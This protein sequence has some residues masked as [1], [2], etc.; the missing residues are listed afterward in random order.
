MVSNN[1]V[2]YPATSYLIDRLAGVSREVHSFDALQAADTLFGS[3]AP[4]NF[5]LVGAA[6]QSGALMIPAQCIEEAIELNGVAVDANVAAFRWGRLA[7]ADRARFNT[8]V[9]AKLRADQPRAVPA[10]VLAKMTLDGEVRAFV[11][12]RVADLIDY[13]SAK[14]ADDYVA[15]VQ[16]VW[17]AERFVSQQTH[18]TAA[19]AKGLFKL[20]AYKDEYE[21]ARLLTDPKFTDHVAEQF[22]T[23]T[24]LTYKLHPPLL[25]AI[26]RKKKI[27]LGPRSHIA[28]RILAKGRWLRGTPLDLF[29]YTHMRRVERQLVNEYRAVV[30]GLVPSLTEANYDRAVAIACLPD[31]VRGYEHIKLA[32]IGSYHRRLHDLLNSDW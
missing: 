30:L 3:T 7:I 6:Y 20:T 4:A 28:L 12:R 22:P 24:N 9:A 5:L 19:V 32:N 2:E 13:Q 15:V 21:V 8:N 11:E 18:L 23:G 14:V 17:D 31:M 27:A 16:T 25:R 10:S 26:G 1:A 29:G